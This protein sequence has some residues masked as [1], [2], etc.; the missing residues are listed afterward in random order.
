MTTQ[1]GMSHFRRARDRFQAHISLSLVCHTLR[2]Y[3]SRVRSRNHGT[4]AQGD[5]SLATSINEKS[6]NPK[7]LPDGYREARLLDR[8]PRPANRHVVQQKLWGKK[9]STHEEKAARESLLKAVSF[10]QSEEIRWKRLWGLRGRDG[11][12]CCRPQIQSCMP[13]RTSITRVC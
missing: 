4:S 3:R 11:A 10:Y 5:T 6:P 12:Q 13:D 9:A 1:I 2:Q 8:T 7:P